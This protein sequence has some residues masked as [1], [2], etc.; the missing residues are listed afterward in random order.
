MHRTRCIAGGIALGQAT[1]V[2]TPSDF[3]DVVVIHVRRAADRPCA[4]FEFG[5]REWGRKIPP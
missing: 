2:S 3:A 5:P 4:S 1:P